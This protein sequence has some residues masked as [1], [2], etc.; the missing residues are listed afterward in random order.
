MN[1]ATRDVLS[2]SLL[3][4]VMSTDVNGE[5][6]L[7][8]VDTGVYLRTTGAGAVIVDLLAE[9]ISPAQ[10]VARLQQEYDVS[11]EDAEISVTEFVES[12]RAH[13]MIAPP[14]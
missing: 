3:P 10:I 4:G 14:D 5:T 11:L 12:L 2:I 8:H 1:Q 13:G 6:Y 9:P 7:L